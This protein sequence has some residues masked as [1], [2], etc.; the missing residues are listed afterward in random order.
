[1][2]EL[3]H[4]RRLHPDR[5][6]PWPQAKGLAVG[7]LLAVFDDGGAPSQTVGDS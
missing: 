3:D 7:A 2:A 5:P 1:M 4:T 6:L